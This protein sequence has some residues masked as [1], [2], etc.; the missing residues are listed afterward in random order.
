M[1]ALK[2]KYNNSLWKKFRQNQMAYSMQAL[3]LEK[4]KPLYNKHEFIWIH[5]VICQ[6]LHTLKV[7][8]QPQSKN[9]RANQ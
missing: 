9:L 8:C 1:T 6:M 7:T 4:E 3:E 2:K 5:Y